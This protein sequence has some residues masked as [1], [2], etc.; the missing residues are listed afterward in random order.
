[1]VDSGRLHEF[2]L[3][4]GLEL[5][6]TD[7]HDFAD[8]WEALRVRE[9]WFAVLSMLD[10]VPIVNLKA[11]PVDGEALRQTYAE[12]TP[13]YH[14]NKRHWVTLRPGESLDEGLVRELVR[15]SYLLVVLGLPK[16]DR[17]VNPESFEV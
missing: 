13:G 10:G 6:A 3:E 1:M 4:V 5:P 17:P 12:I 16:K 9:K 14:M 8:D 2:V 11:D 7:R 15:A